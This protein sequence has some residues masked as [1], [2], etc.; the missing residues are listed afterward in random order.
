MIDSVLVELLS[1]M[2]RTRRL[3]NQQL[4][5]YKCVWNTHCLGRAE[6]QSSFQIYAQYIYIS[7]T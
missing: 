7:K 2:T 6:M 5:Y 3:D 4:F 1:V